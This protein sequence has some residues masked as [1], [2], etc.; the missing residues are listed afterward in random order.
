[1]P[2]TCARAHTPTYAKE[3]SLQPGGHRLKSRSATAHRP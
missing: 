1:V 2:R 3:R